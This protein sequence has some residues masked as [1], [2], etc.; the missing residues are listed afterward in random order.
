MPD[1]SLSLEP[2][3][4]VFRMWPKRN[5]GECIALFPT[6]PADYDGLLCDSYERVGQHGGADYALV[7]RATRPAKPREY[8]PLKRE[9]EHYPYHY[10]LRVMR[11][12]HYA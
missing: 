4:V 6:C 1:D 5:G 10:V 7:I 2:V 9:L 8:L 12:R 11:R 3:P